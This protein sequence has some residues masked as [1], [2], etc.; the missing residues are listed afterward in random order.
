M[1]RI[2]SILTLSQAGRTL[3]VTLAHL[4]A[5]AV[6]GIKLSG[7]D[8]GIAIRVVRALVPLF[9]AIELRLD[10]EAILVDGT[11]SADALVANRDA[12]LRKNVE[13]VAAMFDGL[14]GAM[15]PMLAKV[16]EA[17][18]YHKQRRAK[19][20][21]KQLGLL[22]LVCIGGLATCWTV[23]WTSKAKLGQPCVQT[24]DCRSGECLPSE[25]VHPT[26]I[27]DTVISV[28]PPASNEGVCTTA[29]TSD[30]DCPSSMTCTTVLQTEAF[31]AGGTHIALPGGTRVLRCA[32][33]TR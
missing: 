4:D 26:A 30:A 24:S 13:A 19:R 17:R 23:K 28:P 31:E 29:C 21:A 15:E 11:Q 7:Q 16:D 32:P 2:A 9:G 3:T 22:M 20:E 18:E 8:G 1:R 27:G 14:Q 25:P 5:V 33:R 6:S 12:I 10:D